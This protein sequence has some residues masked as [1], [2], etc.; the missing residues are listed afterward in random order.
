MKQLVFL[1]LVVACAAAGLAQTSS[2]GGG[3]APYQP[4]VPRGSTYMGGGGWPGYGTPTTAAGAAMSG[5]SQ[6][7]SSAGQYNLATSAAAVNMTQAI[8]NQLGNDML[9]TET[10]FGMRA[11][12]RA[13]REREAEP[14]LTMQQ[15]VAI[16]HDGAP[17]PLNS[18]DEDPITGGLNWPS[19]LQQ[20]NFAS[21]RKELDEIFAKRA[22]YGGLT[23]A[24]QM[25]AKRSVDGMFTSLK[26]QIRDIPP[27]D[28]VA[29]RDFLRTLTY[30]AS[31]SD[32]R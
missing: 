25:A 32:L 15:L 2:S 18:R 30:T 5:M 4:A 16:A 13:A 24:D 7:I 11:A 21:G 28:Y 22:R 1:G 8:H 10:Y 14:R 26:S 3:S 19:A 12:N 9:A 20:T 29:C 31:K 23:Y 17:K 6:V 27:Q